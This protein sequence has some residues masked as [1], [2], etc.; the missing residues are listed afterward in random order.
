VTENL[1]QNVWHLNN[2]QLQQD[3]AVLAEQWSNRRS[4]KELLGRLGTNDA[5]VTGADERLQK[6]LAAKFEDKLELSVAVCWSSAEF[7]VLGAQPY[8][9][10][11]PMPTDRVSAVVRLVNGARA[12]SEFE[13]AEVEAA[14]IRH[15]I[16]RR[17]PSKG[18]AAAIRGYAQLLLQLHAGLET[19]RSPASAPVVAGDTTSPVPTVPTAEEE[20]PK[21]SAPAEQGDAPPIPEH[22]S[23]V[24]LR[25][26]PVLVLAD[27]AGREVSLPMTAEQL[28]RVQRYCERGIEFR[29]RVASD[30]GMPCVTKVV[31]VKRRVIDPKRGKG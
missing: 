24:A 2:E 5:K 30:K 20:T 31:R 6:A 18:I 26:G 14:I 8:F 13:R 22:Q 3:A 16:S 23:V 1:G 17:T 29:I 12:E 27:N 7:E 10:L 21:P 9:R 4:V 25:G 11:N 28:E 15:I 19:G